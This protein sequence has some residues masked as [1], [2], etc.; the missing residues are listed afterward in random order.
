MANCP[1]CPYGTQGSYLVHSRADKMEYT[2]L[3]CSRVTDPNPKRETMAPTKPNKRSVHLSVDKDAY[4]LAKIECAK[5]DLDLSHA[6]ELLWIAWSKGEI[7][8]KPNKHD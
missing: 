4:R 3:S 7:K 6:T 1:P 8:L 5:Q 2:R